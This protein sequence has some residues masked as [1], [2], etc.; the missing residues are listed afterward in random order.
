LDLANLPS[1]DQMPH[2][3][4]AASE[5]A[6]GEFHLDRDPMLRA[7]LIRLGAEDHLLLL[8]M[9]HIA[10]D[11]WSSEVVLAELAAHYA[12]EIGTAS[13][14]LRPVPFQYGDFAAW[15]LRTSRG[16]AFDESLRWWRDRLDGAPPLL[17][18]ATDR[19]RPPVQ[20]TQGSAETFVVPKE[21]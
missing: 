2:A 17:E 12:A 18:L 13:A 10:S 16:S 6:Q 8:T 5:E 15:Q 19:P 11:G 9:H 7:L 4:A 3:L 14:E 20:S 21:M 1:S